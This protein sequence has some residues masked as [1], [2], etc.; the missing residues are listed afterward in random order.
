MFKNWKLGL[1]QAEETQR[2]GGEECAEGPKELMM[3]P[4]WRNRVL[5]WT[6]VASRGTNHR[7]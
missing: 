7:A 4:P 3:G 2:D 5:T 6:R 1:D